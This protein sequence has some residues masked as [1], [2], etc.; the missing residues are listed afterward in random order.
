MSSVDF[1]TEEG[2]GEAVQGNRDDAAQSGPFVP[3][4]INARDS[5]ESQAK[6]D[7]C[8]STVSLGL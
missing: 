8:L 4:D 2:A 3:V 7:C 5:G 6:V 1:F